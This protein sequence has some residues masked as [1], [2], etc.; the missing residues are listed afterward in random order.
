[1]RSVIY[2]GSFVDDRSL[3]DPG[4]SS[5]VFI[6]LAGAY[7]CTGTAIANDVI[8]TAAHC[9][10]EA[11]KRNGSSYT[12]EVFSETQVAGE[13]DL[14]STARKVV[15]HPEAQVKSL[16]LS[17]FKLSLKIKNDVALIFL[18]A[19]LP[20]SVLPARLP[21]STGLNDS[22]QH[23][24]VGYGQ[25]NDSR[26]RMRH[27]AEI[28]FDRIS[29]VRVFGIPMLKIDHGEPSP[30]SGDSGGPLYEI[31]GNEVTVL[32]A[33]ST[34]SGQCQREGQA[35]VALLSRDVVQWIQEIVRRNSTGN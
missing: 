35:L 32:G 5:T 29:I 27:Q 11:T 1:M 26:S 12:V 4:V 7:R 10:T 28:S 31:C 2:N 22:C 16:D 3:L 20:P 33:I 23:K 24:L 19:P 6:R 34:G 9:L 15:I 17:T 21:E 13:F 25:T 18:T 30:C 8:L 14:V